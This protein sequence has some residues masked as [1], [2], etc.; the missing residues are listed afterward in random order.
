V[1]DHRPGNK[2]TS[3]S[4]NVRRVCRCALS[5]RSHLTHLTPISLSSH[6]RLTLISP[7]L[8]LISLSPRSHLT[9]ISFSSRSHLTL[10]SLSSRSHTLIAFASR[11]R[12]S[13]V[14]LSCR[15]H[16]TPISLSSPLHLIMACSF[17]FWG[18]VWVITQLKHPYGQIHVTH[19]QNE[20]T[21]STIVKNHGQTSSTTHGRT[22][23]RNIVNNH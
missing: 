20:K 22:S 15:S 18:A 21:W 11:S 12:L 16:L 10:I 13:F 19:I 8:I 1:L 23:S 7:H 2:G 17:I 4:R 3:C 14:A 5:R 6:F 9:L